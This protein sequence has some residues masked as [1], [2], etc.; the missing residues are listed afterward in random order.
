MH[1]TRKDAT[2]LSGL[3]TGTLMVASDAAGAEPRNPDNPLGKIT[4]IAMSI[5]KPQPD[6]DPADEGV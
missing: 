2:Y 5:D 1:F 4:Q 3:I 6:D